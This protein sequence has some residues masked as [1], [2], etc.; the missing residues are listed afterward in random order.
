MCAATSAHPN[1]R[2]LHG[3]DEAPPALRRLRAGPV[4]AL[5]DGTDLRRITVGGTEVVRRIYAAVRDVNWDTVIPERS[6]PTVDIREQ[7]F[8]ISYRASY[9]REELGLSAEVTIEGRP[10]GTLRFAFQGTADTDFPYCRIGICVLHPPTAAGQ[11]YRAESPDGTI[12]GTLPLLIGP[13]WIRDGRLHAL[14]PPYRRLII[15][16]ADGLQVDF[17][18]EGDLFEMEDQRNWTDASF[19]TY[20]TPLAL[21]F[22]HQA[23]RG[24]TFRQWVEV[25][26]LARIPTVTTGTL[27]DRTTGPVTITVGQ[28]RRTGLPAIGLGTSSVAQALSERGVDL[29]RVVRPDHLRLEVRTGPRRVEE[30]ELR[31]AL[32]TCERLN[33]GLEAVLFLDGDAHSELERLAAALRGAPVRRFLV[34]KEGSACSDGALVRAARARL[35]ADHPQA[36]FF[37]GTY[38]YIADLNRT[39]PDPDG[40]DGFAFTITPQVHDSD[41]MS[42]M[43]NAE[44]QADAVRTALALAGAGRQVVVSPVTL[45][46]RFNPFANRPIVADP[47]QLPLAVDPRQASLFAAAWT[48]ASLKHIVEAGAAAVTYY[49][50]VGWRGLIETEAGPPLPG[51]FASRPGMIFP[52]YWVFRDLAGWRGATVLSAD[53]SDPR[54]ATAL[55]LHLDGRTRML[56]ANLTA[57]MQECQL[58]LDAYP[59]EA[60]VTLT[61]DGSYDLVPASVASARRSTARV[62][63][64]DGRLELAL[65]P[66]AVAR[67]DA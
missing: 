4:A 33:T 59:A 45:R 46:P 44:A 56:V 55:A 10:D 35:A 25:R 48:V 14:F 18:F 17:L 64:R 27:A 58:R 12:D 50:T 52:V 40:T 65:N 47:K 9:R 3:R 37:G 36:R 26:C 5:F 38:I 62:P 22:P 16:M 32:S 54:R 43:E 34:F 24:Q 23:R 60:E 21:G 30:P 67:V 42:L 49:E 53:N 39:R 6:A 2:F 11:P 51:R 13:Q 15:D 19:K 1:Y 41:E 7:Q 57:E 28:P 29:L 61:D 20:S 31:A 66:Y 8:T 63:V